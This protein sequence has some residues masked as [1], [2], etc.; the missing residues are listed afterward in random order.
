MPAE[1]TLVK[2]NHVPDPG[3]RR[4]GPGAHVLYL[5][6]LAEEKGVRLLMSAWDRLAARGGAG[7]PLV[8]AGAGPLQHEVEAWAAG[9]DDVDYRGLQS[10]SASAE[11]MANAVAVVVPST[12]METFGLVAVE[13][14]AAGV[15]AV[16]AAHGGL[17]DLVEDG[18]TGFHHRPSDAESLADSLRRVLPV[19]RNQKMGAAARR[20]YEQDFTPAEALRALLDGYRS[21]LRRAGARPTH[22]GE[23]SPSKGRPNSRT[24]LAPHGGENR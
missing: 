3:V 24:A 9:R 4:T 22:S 13:A 10:R 2:P 14:M 6:R 7:C 12:W 16:V 19:D 8:V 18:V 17:A 21:A 23:Q 1:R 5:G 11:L 15:P 20:R